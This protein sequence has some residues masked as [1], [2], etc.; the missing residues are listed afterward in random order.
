MNPI[1]VI[2]EPAHADVDLLAERIRV[3]LRDERDAETNAAR[4]E[5]H[6]AAARE[7]ARMRRREIGEA[8]LKARAAWPERGPRAKGWGEF[9]GRVGLEQSTAWRYMEAVRS[10]DFMQTH[11]IPDPA[12]GEVE[13]GP[14]HSENDPGDAEVEIDRDTWC[15]PSW[16]TAAIG[17]FDLDPC[18]N[19]RSLV[20][21]GT[22]F[23]LARGQDGL[24]RAPTIGHD[25]R[26]FINPP[27]SDVSPWVA[28]YGHTRFCFLLK[29]DTS[30]KWFA[31]LHASTELILIP[32]KRV[33]FV[34]PPGVPRD[35]AIAQQ[36][37]HA[38]FYARAADATDEIKA[39]SWSW[40][41]EREP[42]LYIVR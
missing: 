26:V 14:E 5:Q 37:P 31:D 40:R 19:D 28:A 21:S 32:R 13:S 9:L 42:S 1:P 27:Y 3:A 36:F 10:P 33:N 18:S 38:L 17:V 11:E 22:R 25:W 6:A 8:L 16:I 12:R 20:Q 30:T 23:E 2:V 39:I 4:W 7:T 35:K 15:T 34:P 41:I 24:E 29:L